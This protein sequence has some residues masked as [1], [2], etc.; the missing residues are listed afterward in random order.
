MI[1]LL[2]ALLGFGS[3][4]LPEFFKSFQDRRDKAHEL[5]MLKVQAEMDAA[6]TAG[7]LEKTLQAAIATQ[8][9]A[10]QESYRTDVEANKEA[11]PWVNAYSATV[12]P[13]ITY[14]FFLL[15]ALVKY[16]QFWLLVHP[17]LPWQEGM[18]MAAAIASIWTEED[19]AIFSAV[20][21]FWF[22]DRMLRNRRAL[23]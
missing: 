23:Q 17:T 13:T 10:V 15:Y 12:R 9:V 6:R 22:G 1:A 21:A 19:V 18:T 16:S 8:N 7:D 4:I 11:N 2:S 14:A 3:S 20:I 5:A